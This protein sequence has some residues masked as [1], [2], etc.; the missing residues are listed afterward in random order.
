MNRLLLPLVS[1][2]ALLLNACGL[3]FVTGSGNIIRESRSVVDFDRVELSVPGRMVLTQGDSEALEISA[4]DNLMPYILTK[5]EGGVLSIYVAEPLTNLMPSKEIVYTLNVKNLSAL[6]V[7][8]SAAIEAKQVHSATLVLN[9]NG[10]GD[11]SLADVTAKDLDAT[12]N[13]SGTFNFGTLRVDNARLDVFGS[14]D[15]V[16]RSVEAQQ[17]SSQINGSGK[18][19]L[20]GKTIQQTLTITGAGDMQAA[21]LESE[22]ARVSINGSGNIQVWVTEKLEASILGSGEIGYRGRPS[23]VQSIAGSGNIW[24]TEN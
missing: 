2:M 8:G 23:V 19:T 14:G 13:G 10:S 20:N 15:V 6:T 12:I 24:Q 5:V 22:T 9:I 16:A 1:T 4:D 11:I 18:V 21:Q 7:N 3:N 17:I